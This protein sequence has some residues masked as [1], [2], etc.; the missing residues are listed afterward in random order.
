MM[1]IYLREKRGE[2]HDGD[3]SEREKR[4]R[5]VIYLRERRETGW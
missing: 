3:I 2:R 1:V 5:M 4:D